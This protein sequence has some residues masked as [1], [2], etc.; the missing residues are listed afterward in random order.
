MYICGL[1]TH[2]HYLTKCMVVLLCYG[3]YLWECSVISVWFYICELVVSIY[4]FTKS[5]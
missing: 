2:K 1:Y 5:L 4:E 3:N